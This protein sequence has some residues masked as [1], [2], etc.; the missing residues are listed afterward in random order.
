M[1]LEMVRGCICDSLTVDGVEE[2]SIP[3]DEKRKILKRV[4]EK[5]EPRD[6]NY[7]LQWFMT[8][9][10]EYDCDGEPCEC[11]GDIVETW[12]AEI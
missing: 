3:L 7:L 1:K 4:C 6:L 12:T 5:I 2:F 9:Y 11:C 8:Q 10:G